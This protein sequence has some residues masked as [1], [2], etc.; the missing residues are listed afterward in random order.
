MKDLRFGRSP[1][2]RRPREEMD[3]LLARAIQAYY[4]ARRQ[5][6]VIAADQPNISDSGTETHYG[7]R[8]VVLRS[9]KGTLAVY[10]V[11]HDGGLKPLKRW[12]PILNIW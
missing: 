12:P 7:K 2:R 10:R 4:V 1:K 9:G 11:R 3:K 6:G 5:E 8:Y